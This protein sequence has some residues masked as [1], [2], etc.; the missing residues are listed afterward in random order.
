MKKLLLILLTFISLD[1]FAQIKVKE[2]SFH[3]IN[4][5]VMM[6][7]NEH[8]DM[9]NS[10]MALIKISTENIK[11]E[12]RRRITFKGNLATY[13]DVHFEPTEI[14]LYITAKAATFIEI[15]HPDYG[16]T[17]FT[18]PYDLKDFCG[19]EMVLQYV[20]I[21]NKQEVIKPQNTYLVVSTDQDDAVIYID[22]EYAGIKE[23]SK[24]FAIGT[25]HEWRIECDLYHSE[26]GSLILNEKTEIN[27]NLRP[28]YG[29]I[30]V[31]SQPEN[32]A[33]VFINNKK[34]GETPYQS[35]KL[36]SG[37][38]TVKV[39][40]D[41][42]LVTEKTIEVVDGQNT[43]AVLNMTANF[44]NVTINTDLQS[45]IYIDEEFKGKGRW[46]GRLSDGTHFVEVKKAS[47]ETSC[48]NIDLV[49]GNDAI[50]T[51]EAPKPIYGFLDIDSDP[52][53]SDI[54]IDGKHYGQTPSV[55]S[56]ILIGTHELKLEKQGCVIL[57]KSI[58]I[59][60]NETLNLNEKLVRQFMTKQY[61]IKK[62]DDYFKYIVSIDYP[63]EGNDCLVDSIRRWILES[64]P[65]NYN[66]TDFVNPEEF[67]Q[68]D[69]TK[70]KNEWD[71]YVSDL[72]W[73]WVP[74]FD[75]RLYYTK[76]FESDNIVTFTKYSYRYEGGAH[77]SSYEYGVSF[78]R[79]NGQCLGWDMFSSTDGLVDLIID[80]LK[81][82][83]FEV[84]SDVDFFNKLMITELLYQ[85][86]N[87]LNFPFP[88]THPW[89]TSEGVVFYYKEYEI[90]SYNY[91]SPYCVIPMSK[92]KHL[93]T[94]SVRELL[95]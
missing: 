40:K 77:G 51:I 24:S 48:R 33:F 21:G 38:Y 58:N 37:S 35:D 19:Y 68:R 28:A 11:A 27:K 41:M 16:K 31:T 46:T 75:L 76:E 85:E 6:D 22:G 15:H 12:E 36:A 84:V 3:Q 69:Y 47:H 83:Y 5:Y 17:E 81:Q 44:V 53:K 91:G 1:I 66:A 43:K 32:G 64:F 78:M 67:F 45:D 82:Q 4:G 87:R 34:V 59:E 70:V 89:I 61:S 57:T 54:Y 13:F 8:L 55:I 94:D 95:E 9:N 10:P 93:L 42:F 26:S 88:E 86:V 29:F 23:A 56:D 18:L 80:G 62:E 20:P 65:G 25:A 63:I 50:F 74:G 73:D 60:E 2:D 14:H 79:A 71:I 49:L 52:M 30:N 92:I 72:D 7:K 90:T 39:M